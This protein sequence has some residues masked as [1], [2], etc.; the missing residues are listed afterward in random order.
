MH[1]CNADPKT[2]NC[3]AVWIF[4]VPTTASGQSQ[5]LL[6]ASLNMGTLHTAALEYAGCVLLCVFRQ[7][8]TFQADRP[9]R[10]VCCCRRA[11]WQYPM[12][13]ENGLAVIRFAHHD[14]P[15]SVCF[16]VIS[17]GMCLS[18][19]SPLPL[20]ISRCAVFLSA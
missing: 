17:S 14:I 15:I 1:G 18:D 5:R 6:E 2:H 7:P 8:E 4:C 16:F 11:G 19:I 3:L 20:A 10:A 9:S 13:P 12:L